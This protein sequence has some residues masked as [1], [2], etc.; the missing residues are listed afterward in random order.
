MNKGVNTLNMSQPVPKTKYTNWD[1]KTIKFPNMAGKDTV[2]LEIPSLQLL[3]PNTALSE[4]FED[5]CMFDV[6]DYRIQQHTQQASNS[7]TSNSDTNFGR[8]K[9]LQ[10]SYAEWVREH[11]KPVVARNWGEW[12]AAMLE[13]SHSSLL[14]S[15]VAHL[16]RGDVTPLVQPKDSTST[17][18]ILDKLSIIKPFQRPFPA[19]P[20]VSN[21]KIVFD[22]YL[23]NT[24][25]KKSSPGVPDHRICVARGQ[26]PPD[27]FEVQSTT[28][29][30][31]DDVP[32]HWAVVNSGEISFF[33]FENSNLPVHLSSL[34]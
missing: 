25:F 33:I 21:V 11:S 1:F 27:F 30:L 10:F 9:D 13:Q 5:V 22:V 17:A 14:E 18:A 24:S 23:P 16:W 28:T 20:S 3:P 6:E 34:G 19:K 15:P 4:E 31:E 2:V 29:H 7:W 32:L 26:N 8:L 12:K